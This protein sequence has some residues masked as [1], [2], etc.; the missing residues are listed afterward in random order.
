M[1]GTA[2]PTII[3]NNYFIHRKVAKY[4]EKIR[5]KIPQRSLRL[6]RSGR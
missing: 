5:R 4:A 6:E 2:H 1:V 3:E